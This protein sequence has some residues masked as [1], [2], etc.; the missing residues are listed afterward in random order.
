MS[1]TRLERTINGSREQVARA[2]GEPE[3]IA[4]WFSPNPS[5]STTAEADVQAGGMWR[6]VMGEHTVSGNYQ[7]V[8]LPERLVFTWHWEHEPDAPPSTVRVT[9]SERGPETTELLLEHTDLPDEGEAASLN[10]GWT[11]NLDRLDQLVRSL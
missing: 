8:E 7:E 11:L 5:L 3:L 2:W 6:V 1:E 10:E 4:Q 9:F